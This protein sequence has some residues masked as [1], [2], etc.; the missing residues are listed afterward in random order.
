MAGGAETPN[1]AALPAIARLGACESAR[2]ADAGR[3]VKLLIQFAVE[4]SFS[5]AYSQFALSREHSVQ[6]WAGNFRRATRAGRNPKAEVMQFHD[7]GDHTQTQAQAF[8][9]SSFV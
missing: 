4:G 8:G 6:V 5:G 3:H 2:G 9:V 7:R 1:I